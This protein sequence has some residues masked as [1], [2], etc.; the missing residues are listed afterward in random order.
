MKAT[1]S[2]CISLSSCHLSI[3]LK[4]NSKEHFCS[5]SPRVPSFVDDPM[6]EQ[7]KVSTYLSQG[8]HNKKE[9]QNRFLVL[10]FAFRECLSMRTVQW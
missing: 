3:A 10:V 9:K 1:M 5:L 7:I 8:R 4:T 2:I 6:E